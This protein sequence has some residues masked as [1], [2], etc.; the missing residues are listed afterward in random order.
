MKEE[1]ILL[2]HGSGGKLSQKLIEE[3]M[4]PA[5]SNPA[6][7]EMHDGAKVTVNGAK[8]AFTTDS[9]VVKPLF[10]AGGDI[11]KLAVCGTVN[12][13]AMT[14]AKALYLSAGFIIEEGFPQSDLL[15][16]VDSMRQAAFQAN[17]T[18][19]TGD[20]K[21]VEKGAA[22]G[23]YINTAG[24]GALIEGVNISPQRACS[25]QNII[26]TGSLGDHAVTIMAERHGLTLPVNITSDCAPL[27]G[28]I[29][30]LLYNVPEIAVLRDPTR[31]GLA[32]VLNEVAS[33]A[34]AGIII[35]EMDIPVNPEVMAVCDMLGYDP[36]YLANEGKAVIFV[37][38]VH[39]DKA[40][41]ILKQHVYGRNA[42]V[43]GQVTK[44]PKGQVGLRTLVGGVRLLDMLPGDQLPRIC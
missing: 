27:N 13:L 16:V 44:D 32:T 6:L 10:F 20:T 22:D 36:L 42:K 9:H 1:K 37:E 3:V 21:V 41:A 4:R 14:G 43:I 35:N 40:L 2:A 31:G 12:D 19:V 25:G 38:S 29:E 33:Q 34:Q 30:E 17:V 24:V 8:L 26:L 7:D 18:I 39:T 15:R 23:I 5:F 11:G 28:M